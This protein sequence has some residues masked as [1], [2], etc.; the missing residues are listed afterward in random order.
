MNQN[1]KLKESEQEVR[2]F[3]RFK[4]VQFRKTQKKNNQGLT[5]Q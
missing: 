2:R 5:E 4:E 1:E 3:E